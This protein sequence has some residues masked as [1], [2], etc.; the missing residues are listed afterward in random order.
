MFE[1]DI[2][3][4]PFSD[5]IERGLAF[6]QSHGMGGSDALKEKEEIAWTLHA[7]GSA[8]G[9]MLLGN[10]LL[11]SRTSFSR[12]DIHVVP[13][14]RALVIES[15][16]ALQAIEKKTHWDWYYLA[17]AHEAGRGTP[18]NHEQAACCY[19]RSKEMGNAYAEFE[20]I[21]FH[22]LSHGNIIEAILRF[23]SCE[24]RLKNFAEA[25]ARSLSLI[26]L[27]PVREMGSYQHAWRVIEL[28]RLLH[29]FLYHDAGSRHINIAV[30]AEW[31]SDVRQIEDIRSA[32]AAFVLYLIAKRSRRNP[33]SQEPLH[34][35]RL[36]ATL[37]ST[38][39]LSIVKRQIHNEDELRLLS[40]ICVANQWS[41]S[42]LAQF[43]A[44][45]LELL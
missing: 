3:D 4:D 6:E 45:E 10:S 38:E 32:S 18:V 20:E 37:D 36:A 43:V 28:S 41:H 7:Q 14:A 29:E 30:E 27:G 34:W 33:T 40:D 21:W 5:Y 15:F 24:G 35:L 25:S 2:H 39:F 1:E 23:R 26:A 19:R 9:S 42:E 8:A 13:F 12:K 44:S 11:R 17:V 31:R 16:Q 22:Y